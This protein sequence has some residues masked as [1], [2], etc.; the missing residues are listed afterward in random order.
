MSATVADR[1]TVERHNPNLELVAQGL[2]NIAT[3]FVGGLPTGAI[4]R[5][6]TGI[7]P[8]GRTPVTGVM[9]A[10]TLLG[11]LLV[12]A[13]LARDV[14]LAVLAGI[15]LV[16]A[17]NVGEWGEI[18]SLLNLSKGD[19][20]VWLVTFGLTVFADLTVAVEAG[21]ILAALLMV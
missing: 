20:S 14:P 11:I 8:G 12:A 21:M 4:A 17:N 2:A 7:R 9:H 18:P 3:P 10:L 16:V 5:T 6:A 15:L 1:M 19:I 13:P